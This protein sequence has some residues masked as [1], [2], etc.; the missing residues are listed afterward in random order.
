MEN[1]QD[2]LTERDWIISREETMD[3]FSIPGFEVS[4]NTQIYS[5]K[6]VKSTVGLEIP[7]FIFVSKLDFS[8]NIPSSGMDLIRGIVNR[9]SKKKF[10]QVLEDR[11]LQNTTVKG[12][13]RQ[14]YEEERID[15]FKYESSY[16]KDDQ[17]Y[18]IKS[19]C[20]VLHNEENY[21]VLGYSRPVNE[22][23]LLINS[24]QPV[25]LE[26]EISDLVILIMD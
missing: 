1:I 10:M 6:N 2:H 19:G 17:T 25:D 11:E 5:K 18:N 3:V 7:I 22:S 4:T 9:E 13:E 21:Y 14:Y 16:T 23:I 8:S 20:F 24:D 26:S 15:Q 12:T